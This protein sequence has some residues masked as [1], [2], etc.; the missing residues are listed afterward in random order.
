MAGWKPAPRPRGNFLIRISVRYMAQ[1]KQAAGAA[2]EEVALPAPCHVCDVLLALADRHGAPLRSLLLD[3]GDSL[4]PTILVF[5]G[6]EQVSASDGI[7][8]NDGDILTL[9]SPIAGG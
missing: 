7:A 3:A 9:L 1:L 6:D 5:V 8:L 4:Q 2:C